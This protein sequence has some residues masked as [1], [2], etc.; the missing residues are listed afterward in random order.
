MLLMCR[1]KVVPAAAGV[2]AALLLALP[3]VHRKKED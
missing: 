1:C 2:A 3:L